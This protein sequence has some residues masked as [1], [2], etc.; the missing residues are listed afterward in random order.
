MGLWH[1][2]EA[3]AIWRITQ[4]PVTPLDSTLSVTAR[5]CFWLRFR[6]GWQPGRPA[7]CGSIQT[8]RT[9][10]RGYHCCRQ[11]HS[12]ASSSASA[13]FSRTRVLTGVLVLG[14]AA[15]PTRCTFSHQ[16]DWI[17]I[18]AFQGGPVCGLRSAGGRSPTP[19]LPG[20]PAPHWPMLT[21]TPLDD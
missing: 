1:R 16:A 4:H 14:F 21:L 12:L 11:V 5:C 19:G 6:S 9:R 17:L 13:F 8:N 2:S 20:G 10:A 15:R 18:Q 7:G 3:L